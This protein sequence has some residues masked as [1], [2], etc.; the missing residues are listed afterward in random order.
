MAGI[1]RPK[2]SRKMQ[3]VAAIDILRSW[4]ELGVPARITY[5]QAFVLTNGVVGE[6][7]DMELHSTAA[8]AV[9]YVARSK[10][11]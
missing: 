11:K 10:G 5:D 3:N 8:I 6:K 1:G 9:R 2:G 4:R 7:G